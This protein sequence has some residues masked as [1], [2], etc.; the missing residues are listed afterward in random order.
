MVSFYPVSKCR[1]E[2]L[3]KTP[4]TLLYIGLYVFLCIFFWHFYRR[5][6][7]FGPKIGF[8]FVIATFFLVLCIPYFIGYKPPTMI[9]IGLV[10]FLTFIVAITKLYS[11]FESFANQIM[12]PLLRIN[13]FIL[14]FCI[15]EQWIRF[16]LILTVLF[17]PI[18]TIT[19]GTLVLHPFVLNV[20]IWILFQTLVLTIV[21]IYCPWFCKNIYNVIIALFLPLILH[22]KE[23]RW[24][25]SRLFFLCILLWID[26]FQHNRKTAKTIQRDFAFFEIE[27]E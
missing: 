12:T 16:L 26:L 23:N 15:R 8:Y 22:F 19:N 18:I 11:C 10:L 25:E 6:P 5:S 24:G 14:C 27:S 20:D 3:Y 4:R 17:T 7:K 1:I 13:I 9:K 2:P 21:Y